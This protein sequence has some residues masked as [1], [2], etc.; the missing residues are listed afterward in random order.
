[1][2][3][4]GGGFQHMLTMADKGGLKLDFVWKLDFR[5]AKIWWIKKLNYINL[6][7]A[8]M[9]YQFHLSTAIELDWRH[10]TN[11]AVNLISIIHVSLRSWNINFKVFQISTT[12]WSAKSW[13]SG[14]LNITL[15]KQ[16]LLYFMLNKLWLFVP[17]SLLQKSDKTFKC[18]PN[19]WVKMRI[20]SWLRIQTGPLSDTFCYTLWKSLIDTRNVAPAPAGPSYQ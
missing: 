17:G 16:M 14:N 7:V 12:S 3:A 8:Q 18:N 10:C 2:S 1:M 13:G 4:A 20:L 11:P 9:E 6:C 5:Q 15:C 19:P